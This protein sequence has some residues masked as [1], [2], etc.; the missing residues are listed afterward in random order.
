MNIGKSSKSFIPIGF[1][2]SLIIKLWVSHMYSKRYY[3]SEYSFIYLIHAIYYFYYTSRIGVKMLE[4]SPEDAG[5]L[6][7]GPDAAHVL[8]LPYTLGQSFSYR[9]EAVVFI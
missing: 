8:P 7:D 3:R 4:E 6:E 2:K 9:H 1:N 5:V